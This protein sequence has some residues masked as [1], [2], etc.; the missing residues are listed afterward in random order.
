[1]ERERITISIKKEVLEKIDQRIDGI[2][3]RNRSHAIELLVSEM[4]GMA[5]IENAVIM[6]GGKGALRLI[7]TVEESI[8]ILKN[9]GIKDITIAVGYLGEKIKQEIGNGEKFETKISYIEGGEGTAG[10]LS[11]LRKKLK[12]TF[13]V[14]NIDQVSK[15]DIAKLADFHFNHQPIASIASDNSKLLKGYYLLE[16]EIFT[17]ISTGFSMLEEDVFPKLIADGKL[18]IFPVIS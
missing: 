16:P 17:F 18:L 1:M 15:I 6:A 10:A 14:I 3:M 9:Y 13:L 2:K 4:L 8:R 11:L 5:K 7:P 12:R